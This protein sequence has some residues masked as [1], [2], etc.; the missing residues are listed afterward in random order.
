MLNWLYVTGER[1]KVMVGTMTEAADRWIMK[2]DEADHADS[3]V[4]PSRRCHGSLDTITDSERRAL[5]PITI[6]VHDAAVRTGILLAELLTLPGVRIFQGVRASTADLP[7]I[8]HAISIG[9]QVLLVESVAWPSGRYVTTPAGRIHCDGIYI[10]QSV[11]PLL[12]AIRRWREALPQGHRVSALVIV[13]PSADGD[14]TLPAAAGQDV[15]WALAADAVR[16]IR[17]QLPSDQQPVSIRAVATLIA[18]AAAD[19]NRET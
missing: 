16:Y 17:E 19:E 6:T 10:G 2:S 14:I 3:A 5:R 18:A 15:A 9:R 13:H 11:R 4:R 7:R 8:P 12:A 1:P